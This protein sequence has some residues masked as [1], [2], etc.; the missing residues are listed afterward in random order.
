MRKFFKIWVDIVRA[1]TAEY[2]SL[3][4]SSAEAELRAM[5][6]NL[7]PAPTQKGFPAEEGLSQRELLIKKAHE[8]TIRKCVPYFYLTSRDDLH[9]L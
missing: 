9:L 5:G 8:A 4:P 7:P 1:C 2:P 6:H 3:Y